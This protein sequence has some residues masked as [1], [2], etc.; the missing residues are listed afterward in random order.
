MLFGVRF[1]QVNFIFFIFKCY[2]IPKWWQ[3]KCVD[4]NK[5]INKEQVQST[6]NILWSI[7]FSN[8]R[9]NL[10][11][12]DAGVPKLTQFLDQLWFWLIEPTKTEATADKYLS[13]NQEMNWFRH[14]NAFN[15]NFS[16]CEWLCLNSSGSIWHALCWQSN[17]DGTFNGMEVYG[18]CWRVWTLFGT[19]RLWR[20]SSISGDWRKICWETSVVGEVRKLRSLIARFLKQT[21]II[22]DINQFLWRLLV[23]LEIVK[24]F[25]TCVKDVIGSVSE[26]LLML[27]W[28]TCLVM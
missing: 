17:G 19:K 15:F 26:S 3:C 5:T 27:C 4:S 28:I 21:Y 7:F 24:T 22:S 9:I 20:Y 1:N 6:V 12:L 14:A 25:E 16:D 18:H 8:Y 23:V 13:C 11:W 2:E 10:P